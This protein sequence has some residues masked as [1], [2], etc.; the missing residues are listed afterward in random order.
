MT[1]GGRERTYHL[2]RP[3]ALPD[4]A[5][6][7]VVLHG[8]VGTGQQ[9]EESYGFDAQA[10][11]GKFLVAYPDGLHRTWDVT[12]DCCG[13]AAREGVDDLGFL[14]Q[15]VD[16]LGRRNP[17]DPKRVYAAGISNGALMAY[18]LA[19]DTAIFAA[20]GVVAGTMI[21]PCERPAPV[22]ILHIHG[23]VDRTIPYEGGPGRR[24]NAGA[25]EQNPAKISGPSTEQLMAEWRT[26]N[27][28]GVAQTTTEG[29]V[30]TS[31]AACAGGQEV[32]LISVSGAGHQW[33]G[34]K[35]EPIAER[36]LGLDPPS[37]LLSATSVI[38]KFFAAH[39]KA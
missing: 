12:P 10:D 25:G 35:P 24:S 26:K 36:L 27:S 21:S 3:V 14:T 8:A 30:I 16:T 38:W 18:R 32:E 5:P 39:R 28:C 17:L 6:L 22:S 31:T 34:G 7:V 20:I 11:S 23:T 15:L 1:V 29:Q 19:C 33:P 37:T 9:A 4:G 2:Y 13:G